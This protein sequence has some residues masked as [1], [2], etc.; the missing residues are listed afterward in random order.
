MQSAIKQQVAVDCLV[1]SNIF[2]VALIG[3][4][5]TRN[6]EPRQARKGATVPADPDAPWINLAA[7]FFRES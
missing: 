5:A 2:M 4:L 3:P 6:H 1:I 7:S